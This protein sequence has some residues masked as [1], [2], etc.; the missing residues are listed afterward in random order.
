MC[1]C[2]RWFVNFSFLVIKNW[3]GEVYRLIFFRISQNSISYAGTKDRRGVTTQRMCIKRITA[4]RVNALTHNRL[5]CGN[6]QYKDDPLKL[7]QLK[8]NRFIIALRY[9]NIIISN[10]ISYKPTNKLLT[11]GIITAKC[12][13][14]FKMKGSEI[15]NIFSIS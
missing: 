12:I 6:F 15:V 8:G 3:H 7:G 5:W 10:W 11:C 1:K 2:L 14:D 4:K 9:G 13:I